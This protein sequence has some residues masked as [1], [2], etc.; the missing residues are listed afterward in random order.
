[1]RT[2]KINDKDYSKHLLNGYVIKE[3]LTEE[4]DSGTIILTGLKKTNFDPFDFV[5]ITENERT[6]YLV[7]DTYVENK[8]SS[9]PELYEYTIQLISETKV[10]ERIILPNLKITA[11]KKGISGIKYMGNYL[12]FLVDKYLKPKYSINLSPQLMAELNEV[13]CPEY[14]WQSPSIKQVFNDLL[15][16]LDKPKLV[17]VS[18][19][20]IYGV[21]LSVKGKEITSLKGKITDDNYQASKDYVNNLLMD[22]KNIITAN[23]NTI[24][25]PYVSFRSNDKAYLTTDNLEFYI[26]NAKIE[27]IDKLI[28]NLVLEYQADGSSSY[29]KHSIDLDITKYLIEETF[30]NQLLPEEKINAIYYTRGGDTI[31]GFSYTN[32]I[33][34]FINT[35]PAIITILAKAVREYN[36]KTTDGFYK[37]YTG[38]L[39]DLMFNVSYQNVGDSRILIYRDETKKHDFTLVDNQTSQF[40][41]A[42]SFMQ[43]ER[44]KVNRLGNDVRTITYMYKKINDI[45]SLN[46][47]IDDYYLASKE[48]SHYGG[49]YIFKGVFS[50]DYIQ[51]NIYY[52]LKSRTRFTNFEMANNSVL[53]NENITKNIYFTTQNT[54]PTLQNELVLC[55]YLAR[56]YAPYYNTN[57]NISNKLLKSVKQVIGTS[58]LANGNQLKY[59]LQPSIYAFDKSTIINFRYYDNINVGMKVDKQNVVLGVKYNQDYVSYVDE[60]GEVVSVKFDLYTRYID[61]SISNTNFDDNFNYPEYFVGLVSELVYTINDDVYKDNG[62][63]LQYDIQFNFIGKDDV[64]I[65]NAIGEYNAIADTSGN[66]TKLKD[67]KIYYSTSER[68]KKGDTAPKGTFD[69]NILLDAET[70]LQWSENNEYENY[71]KLSKIINNEFVDVDTSTWESWCLAT[72]DDKIILAVNRNQ[73]TNTISDKIYITTN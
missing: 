68:Y 27:S 49:Y 37:T 51:K 50:K 40:I 48:V 16:T 34:G 15:Q 19:G 12:S 10:L 29:V 45:P 31:K 11:V 72:K 65:G 66:E 32:Q 58:Y 36:D 35:D 2:I 54:K 73:T 17:K 22:T 5:V 52:G 43:T 21:E 38:E 39:R 7:V 57:I 64:V 71:I 60:L 4:L 69:V 26:P 25:A 3:T 33:F 56:N 53:R 44:E 55:N 63:I 28:V 30:Y 70:Y 18:N 61:K 59:F 23:T 24:T 13:L 67:F 62:E 8:I 42:V 20:L 9:I 14:A 46:D 47:Y 6:Y 1:M 41:N